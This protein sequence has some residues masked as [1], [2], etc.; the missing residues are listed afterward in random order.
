MDALRFYVVETASITL[1]SLQLGTVAPAS[2]DDT[3]LRIQNIST[4]YQAQ[5][6]TVS[7]TTSLPDSVQLWLSDDGDTFAGS[8]DLGAI[9]PGGY[10]PTFWLRRVTP[11]TSSTGQRSGMLAAK[12]TQW[13]NPVDVSTSDNTPI[14]T[15]D[16]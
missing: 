9:P 5:D 7:F 1:V 15:E 11:S 16:N 13:T 12:C 3:L 14:T 4:L 8:L 2:S 6:V 10:S